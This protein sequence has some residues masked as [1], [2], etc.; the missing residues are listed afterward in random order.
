LFATL[1]STRTACYAD[2]YKHGDTGE[3]H[4]FVA[5]NHFDHKDS[6]RVGR[7][8]ANA[9]PSLSFIVLGARGVYPPNAD[10]WQSGS[11]D[12]AR[13]IEAICESSAVIL[14]SF[15]EG[16]GFTFMHALAAGKPI[17]AR[18]IPATREIIAQFEGLSGVYLYSDDAELRDAVARAIKTG[19]SS[20]KR[21]LGYDWQKWSADLAVF[22][23]GI[24][25][26]RSTIYSRA[27][28]RIKHGDKLRGQALLKAKSQHAVPATPL[29]PANRIVNWGDLERLPEDRFVD[30]MYEHIL[31]RSPDDVG[32]IHHLQLL[33]DG[34]TKQELVTALF[35]SH[36]YRQADRK[37][38]I[39]NFPIN[40][41]RGF[42]LVRSF[43]R[44]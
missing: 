1:L 6:T 42:S 34:R 4:V 36:E 23:E 19:K 11:V 20:F 35:D 29:A 16:F 28:D 18:D 25:S 33:K 41:G 8:L 12:D 5:G 7:V 17:V 30:E 44:R 40:R 32:K 21:E 37:V 22:L 3:R 31:G 38:Q 43:F 14:P 39:E 15:Y 24:A 26:D 10:V 2:R 13:M 9:F 27:V